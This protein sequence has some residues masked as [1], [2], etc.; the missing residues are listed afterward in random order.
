MVLGVARMVLGSSHF[1]CLEECDAEEI[2][3]A[4]SARIAA[5]SIEENFDIIL[6]NYF[7][8][9]KE[10]MLFSLRS[11]INSDHTYSKGQKNRMA[12]ARK[13]MNVLSAC[14]SYFDNVPRSLSDIDFDNS[15]I[16]NDVDEFRKKKHAES[17]SYQVMEGLRNYAQHRGQ[18]I[19][20]YT[21][22]S[23]WEGEENRKERLRH[24]LEIYI[25]L[26]ELSSDAK[27][28]KSLLQSV[29]NKAD[30]WEIRATTASYIECIWE[31]HEFLR[32]KIKKNLELSD[33]I[34]EKW[35]LKFKEIS[36]EDSAVAIALCDRADNGGRTVVSNLMREPA[37]YRSELIKKN[38][39]LRNL[40]CSY[41]SVDYMKIGRDA[42]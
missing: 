10:C 4:N 32:S 1:I 17:I 15:G 13:L 30:K 20:G 33:S 21:Y 3:R 25:D 37:E 31:V 24:G 39:S 19:H 14:R 2:L 23:S 9:E 5:L 40:S 36:G 7:E 26:D 42:D 35:I 27:F 16:G 12:F 22:G 11:M 8:L 34:I 29:K 28:K 38:S 18:P 6:E 41:V